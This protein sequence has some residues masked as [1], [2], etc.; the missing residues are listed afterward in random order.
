MLFGVPPPSTLSRSLC[1]TEE[2]LLCAILDFTPARISW[3]SP[4]R[5][6]ELAEMVNAREPLLQHTFGFVD[7]KNF[8]VRLHIQDLCHYHPAT[9]SMLL[10]TCC[11]CD[12]HLALIFKM[13]CTA[14]GYTQFWSLARF[15]SLP[16]DASSGRST[17]APG[18]GRIQKHRWDFE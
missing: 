3:S 13:L 16:T 15:A 9:V 5:Q 14:D 17:T 12:N 7:G 4:S 18:P 8:R 6:R 2:A 1:R 11:R 10:S